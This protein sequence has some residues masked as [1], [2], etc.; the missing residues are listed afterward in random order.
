MFYLHARGRNA[1]PPPAEAPYTCN[2]DGLHE[3][4]YGQERHKAALKSVKGIVD[5]SL[6]HSINPATQ[7]I[8]AKTRQF[9]EDQRR[10]EIG[11][12]NRKLV[13]RLQHISR[14]HEAGDPRSPPPSLG[15]LVVHSASDRVRSLNEPLRRKTQR[16]IDED[17]AAL[18]RRVLSAKGTFD[19]AGD[20]KDFQRHKRDSHMLQKL[21]AAPSRPRS[22]P[23]TLPPLR[24]LRVMSS[25]TLPLKGLDMLLLPGDL[26]KPG[27]GPAMIEF[28]PIPL[29]L[30]AAPAAPPPASPLRQP[31]AAPAAPAPASP[32]RQPSSPSRSQTPSEASSPS[33]RTPARRGSPQEHAHFEDADQ[34]IPPAQQEDEA[35]DEYEEEARDHLGVQRSTSRMNMTGTSIAT[36]EKYDDDD[37][38]QESAGGSLSATGKRSIYSP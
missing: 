11:R 31:G 24:P 30:T 27:S 17:N 35:E 37:W 29:A 28:R 38:D 34:E 9:F 8:Q 23:R 25:P 3:W 16:T 2:A 20:E 5:Q 13:E 21:P 22:Q 32:A 19:R 14:G 15:Q 12:E 36:S 4:S 7:S 6:P 1:H 26:R 33:R 10:A 18:V